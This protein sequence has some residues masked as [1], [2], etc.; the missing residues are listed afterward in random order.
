M[1]TVCLLRARSQHMQ[2]CPDRHCFDEDHPLYRELATIL[3]FRRQHR[4]PRRGRQYLRDISGDGQ[5]FGPPRMLGGQLRSIVAWSRIL[6]DQEIL[7]AINTDPDNPRTAWVT[8]D[9]SLHN[10]GDTLA[11]LYSTDP[12]AIGTTTAAGRRNGKAV[13]LTLPPA[14]FVLYQ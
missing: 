6:A 10:E 5:N 7:A 8:I 13:Q 1:T 3:A 11:C 14:G 4:A 2:Q 9:Q 12:T